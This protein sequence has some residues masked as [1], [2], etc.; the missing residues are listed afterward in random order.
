MTAD[1]QMK[2]RRLMDDHGERHQ[3]FQARYREKSDQLLARL[4]PVVDGAALERLSQA[5]LRLDAG[6]LT[7]MA[8]DR[9][10]CEEELASLALRPG[11]GSEAHG[12]GTSEDLVKLEEHLNALQPFLKNCFQHPRFAQLLLD[13]YG[14]NDYP[15]RF[16]H[17]SYY[18]DR[19]AAQELEELCGGRSFASIRR[20]AVQALEASQVLKQ[21]IKSLKER[22]R[23]VDSVARRKSTL[24]DRLQRH[25]QLWLSLARRKL[26]DVLEADFIESLEKCRVLAPDEAFQWRLSHELCR[27]HCDLETRFLRP[28]REA[29]QAGKRGICQEL[30]EEYE[31][32][33]EVLKRFEQP[34]E[35][36][37]TID[38]NALI[39]QK[40]DG[41]P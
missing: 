40:T 39:Y 11:G 32:L 21:R 23:T 18:L 13:G 1:L 12:G 36:R 2:L 34:R 41:P 7:M 38:W 29:Q 19:R 33:T 16:W 35:S 5:G 30:L 14:T 26:L 9:Q 10:S 20:E 37:E 3:R 17:L 28:A 25:P 15:K 31:A 4:L 8:N 27:E 24:E 6:L 22:Q